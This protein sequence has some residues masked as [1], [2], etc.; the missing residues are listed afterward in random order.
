MA[1]IR[2]G[3]VLAHQEQERRTAGQS[4]SAVH[5]GSAEHRVT[6][7]KPQPAWRLVVALAGG[8][9]RGDGKGRRSGH[10]VGLLINGPLAHGPVAADWRAAE[11]ANLDELDAALQAV[12]DRDGGVI[13]LPLADCA[14]RSNEPWGDAVQALVALVALALPRSGATAITVELPTWA[15]GLDRAALE[16]ALAALARDHGLTVTITAVTDQAGALAEAVA[17]TWGGR[18]E[19]ELARIRQSGL[20]GSC[21]LEPSPALRESLGH[22]AAGTLPPWPAWSSLLV[23]AS[24]DAGGLADAL[25]ARIASRLAGDSE[26]AVAL[27]RHLTGLARGRITDAPRLARELAWLEASAAAQLRPRDRLRLDSAIVAA[28]SAAGSLSAASAGRLIQRLADL[29][30]DLPAETVETALHASVSAREALDLEHAELFIAPWQRTETVGCGGR[31]LFIRLA[32]ERARVA[33]A[34]SRWKDARKHLDR[35]DEAA[36]K[37]ADEQDRGVVQARLSC[38]RVMVLADDPASTEG[39]VGAALAVMAG[40]AQPAAAAAEMASKGIHGRRHAHLALLRAAVRRQDEVLC[41]TYVARRGEWC[42]LR[43][44][45]GAQISALRAVLLAATDAD[46][47]R[48]LLAE[49]AERQGGDAAP[50]AARLGLAACAVAAAL[51]GA[52]QP[53]LR[54]RLTALRRERPQ[55]ALAV[56]ALERA[57]ALH[58]DTKAGLAE[59]LPLLAR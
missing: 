9:G 29:R 51:L 53:E 17:W 19:A 50:T 46:A 59:A 38:L 4:L 16:T 49:A 45:P 23:E 56:A 14:E 21:L 44:A 43:E 36:A 20:A 8:R 11:C 24:A 13:G 27:H 2:R 10:A 54:D 57:L 5:L 48:A 7:L 55:S 39:D 42:D 33:A 32:E 12:A 47:A 28:E 3:D 41:G 40:T 22:L 26:A 25:L 1:R 30:E 37:L 18:R 31:A 15:E 35:A 58:P 6:H 52:A 34:E